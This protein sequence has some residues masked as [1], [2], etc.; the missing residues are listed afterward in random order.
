MTPPSTLAGGLADDATV[1]FAWPAG[2]IESAVSYLSPDTPPSNSY[3]VNLRRRLA[4]VVLKGDA[5]WIA[6]APVLNALGYA[7]TPVQALDDLCDSVEQYLEYLRED[8][9]HLAATA[10]HHAEYIGL[11][12]APRGQ[13]FASVVITEPADASALE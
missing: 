13:W 8:A 10:V 12:D 7:A 4:V 5:G 3:A 6:K 1:A 9:P 2:S 11:L